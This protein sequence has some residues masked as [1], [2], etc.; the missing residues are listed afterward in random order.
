[1]EQ[2]DG[3]RTRGGVSFDTKDA[4][5]RRLKNELDRA[6]QQATAARSEAAE[7]RRAFSELA[8]ASR[9]F[10]SSVTERAAKRQPARRR[11]E[12][13]Y[14]I[15]QVLSRFASLAES[16]PSLLKILGEWLGC[17]GIVLW[18]VG[19]GSLGRASVV[20]S[21]PEGLDGARLRRGEG[22][23]GR[24][25]NEGRVL[26]EEPRDGTG[27]GRLAFPVRG[28]RDTLAVIECC[29][30]DGVPPDDAL[31]ATISLVGTQV[32][33]AAERWQA[34]GERDRSLARERRARAELS[35]ILESVSD[36]FF[37]LDSGR[38]FTYVNREAERLWGRERQDLLGRVIWE[39]FPEA[40]G[41]GSYGA[42]ERALEEGETSSFET[43]SPVLGAWISGHAYPAPGGGVSVYFQDITERRRAEEALRESEARARLALDVARLGTWSW[44]PA[45]DE[46]QADARC[47]EICGLGLVSG[48]AIS[49]V[50][51]RVHPDDRARIEA[52]LAA[53]VRPEG[54]GG[55]AEESR[56][57]HAD[58]SLRWVTARG[59]TTFEGEGPNRRPKRLMG[60][61]L[62]VTEQ[63][64][65]EEALRRSEERLRA[66]ID[67]GLDVI[68]I[69]DR[70]GRI[71]FASPSVERVCG[72]TVEEFV[73][74][75]PF[76]NGRIHPDD[77]ARCAAS[78]RELHDAPG[79]SLTIQHRYL[80]RSGEWRW[81]EGSFTNLFDDPAVG[82]LVANFRDIT[83]RKAA[84]EA[85]RESE[86]RFR[87]LVSNIPGAVYR[88]EWREE[89]TMVFVSDG[90]R[91][92][93]G[94]EP[95]DFVENRVRSYVSLIYPEDRSGLDGQVMGA[96]MR[97]EPYA[98]EYRIRHADGG[99]RWINE[100]G[101]GVFSEGGELLYLDG[102]ILDVTAREEARRALAKSEERL[103]A[104]VEN[105][106]IVLCAIDHEG[107]FRL[108]EGRGLDTLGFEPSAVVG[109]SV[110]EVFQ[111]RAEV[112]Q[113]ARRAL[114][115]ESFTVIREVNGALWESTYTPVLDGT[116]APAGTIAVA[117]DV[118]DRK[119][120]EE[121]RDRRRAQEL[122]ARAEAGERQRISRELHDRVAHQMGVVHQSLELY[123]ALRGPDP[124]RAAERLSLAREMAKAALDATRNLSAE[125]RRTEAEEGLEQA[126]ADL[127][128][129]FEAPGFGT[130]LSVEGDEELLPPHVRGQVFI[131]LR[132]A[133]RNAARHSGGE[134]VSVSVE[135]SPEEV[136]GRVE[137]EGMGFEGTK[138]G[139]MGLRSMRERAVL[140]GGVLR[141]ESGEGSG[142][143]V[144]V[145]VPLN[146]VSD[147]RNGVG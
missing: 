76:E 117:T 47:R 82:G 39:V 102:A 37:A 66:L 30:A 20:G 106:P 44:D 143:K 111:G 134:G 92:I 78:F 109:R 54:D 119:R 125:L 61:V 2:R 131:I 24:V 130:Q 10:A 7:A 115:G 116:G 124:E 11:L 79:S 145:R 113:D 123:R 73:G 19:S 70:D 5:I 88:C 17:R 18:E 33:Q 98:L 86:E 35:G 87:T 55:Y 14:E 81:L 56:F 52:A 23:A 59:Q 31:L 112:L 16:S 74:T 49:D 83:G 40:A 84:E 80:H 137:D 121:E 93:T 135:I 133:V 21:A 58:G 126:L 139:T 68:T 3:Q 97:G 128:D 67:K 146:G 6:R 64:Q 46:V 38:R 36:A 136:V 105:I 32:G 89:P 65:S 4:E 62:D 129:T 69:S 13:Q 53:A 57:V 43:V 22:L 96:L 120:A 114:A 63:R 91:E 77:A 144:E 85:V 95:G 104:V 90:I 50:A 12:V 9:R 75:D 132:E 8:S 71:R 103:R 27:G 94:H 142:T 127:L 28:G 34:E 99:V 108:S 107:V 48:L 72:Y 42:V 122:A 110:F 45:G 15:S 25:W 140:L 26:W 41:S 147:G 29:V 1:V 101:V 138:E 51:S 118:T 141:I 60:T 100:R